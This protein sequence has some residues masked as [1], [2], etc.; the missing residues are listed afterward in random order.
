MVKD[1]ISGPFSFLSFSVHSMTILFSAFLI[2]YTHKTKEECRNMGWAKYMEDDLELIENRMGNQYYEL[3]SL[4]YPSPL[5]APRISVKP[6]AQTADTIWEHE[7]QKEKRIICKDC[8]CQIVFSAEQQ[9]LYSQRGWQPPKRCKKCRSLR[10]TRFMMR[11][12][13]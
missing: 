10:E 12:S 2:R 3:Y 8:G 5:P 6:K 7:I 1:Q 11:S 4:S 9:L 13:F